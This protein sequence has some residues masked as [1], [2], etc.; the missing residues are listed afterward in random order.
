MM[1]WQKQQGYFLFIAVIFIL[2]MGLMGVVV[3]N[4]LAN[5]AQI[6][7]MQQNGLDSFYIAE[8]GLEIGTRLLTR[9]GIGGSPT[10]L[11]CDSLAGTAQVTNAALDSGT[12]TLT[13]INSS[14][15]YTA[16]TLSS[17][18]TA[19]DTIINVTNTA[20]LAPSGRILIDHEAI[21]YT[22][23]VGN[24]LVGATRGANNTLA[25]FHANGTVTSQYQCT[26]DS[27]AGVP[28][29]S[30]PRAQREVNR[31]VQL[32]DGW[33]GGILN[34]SNFTLGHWNY[35]AEIAWN[36]LAL[37]GSGNAGN[38][39]G[40]SMLSNADAWAVANEANNN[41]IFLHWN[42]AAWGLTSVAGCNGQNL[43]GIS[44]VSSQEGWA[45]GIRAKA[46]NCNGVQRYTIVR[47]NGSSWTKQAPNTIPA[48]NNGNQDLNAVSVI[49]TT[50]NGT[51]DIGF[52]VGDSG[53]ILRYNG[54]TWTKMTSPTTQHLFGVFVVSTSEAWAVGASGVIL[55]W[56]GTSWSSFGTPVST[57]LNGIAMLDTDG[58]GLADI[59]W[60]VGDSERI[61]TYN[62]SSWSSS[63][64][65]SNN[66]FG[67]DIVN[68]KDA[69]VVGAAGVTMHW[70]GSVWRDIASGTTRQLNTI[71]VIPI[72]KP[73]SGW[74]QVY[75]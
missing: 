65:G 26:I 21:D 66:L 73:S 57:K 5:R 17:A 49:D 55:R 8:S 37:S 29:L 18:V 33:Y 32:Q 20:S 60:A 68:E 34:G 6:S 3:V 16:S 70:D 54:S 62:G 46:N 42:G 39:N 12:F 28:N 2:V 41:L 48:D 23:I 52:A 58:D 44:M 72:R 40:I 31:A 15:V 7:A 14:P 19:A 74:R 59:G 30:Q 67:V 64:F 53:T 47:W 9:S 61:L 63:D 43:L 13:T 24:A 25:S 56:N 71:S 69:W 75:R 11:A 38:I 45:V 27:V 36:S 1:S 10:R 4:L 22:A 35:P 51:G 50:G